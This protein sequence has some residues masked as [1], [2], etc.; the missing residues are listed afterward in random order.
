VTSS[1]PAEPPS[2]PGAEGQPLSTLL[3]ER[4]RSAW[5]GRRH[6]HVTTCGSTND[7]VAGEARGGAGEGLLVTADAQTK[8]RGRLGRSWHSPLGSNLYASVLLRPQRPAAEIPPLTLM[9]GGALARAL[10]GMGFDARVKWPNDLL[11]IVDGQPR[12]VA[13]ILTEAST[14][15]HRIGHVVVGVGVNV[16][17]VAFPDDLADKATSLRL[18]RGAAVARVDVLASLLEAL[19]SAYDRF[20]AEGAAAAIALWEAHADLSRRCRVLVGGRPV[21][22]MPVGLGLD[23]ALHVRDDAGAVHRVVSGEITT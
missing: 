6:I 12:K 7:L 16:N 19:E 17:T 5:L 3:A 13:G 23:G 14:E 1:P 20:K 8:G 10:V 18:A 4:L 22:G 9:A 2:A 11:L 21:E 15:G